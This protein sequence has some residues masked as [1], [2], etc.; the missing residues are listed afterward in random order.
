MSSSGA[1]I[2][3]DIKSFPPRYSV[4]GAEQVRRVSPERQGAAG[5]PMGEAILD[6]DLG[7]DFMGATRVPVGGGE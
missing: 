1:D 5:A 2:D 7:K 3:L 6:L 4:P